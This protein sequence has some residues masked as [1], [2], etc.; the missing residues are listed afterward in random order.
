MSTA[1]I[2]I[3][4]SKPGGVPL[5]PGIPPDAEDLLEGNPA[6][7]WTYLNTGGNTKFNVSAV[8]YD[9]MNYN[10][11]IEATKINPNIDGGLG[12]ALRSIGTW[13]INRPA[14]TIFI[15]FKVRRTAT[16]VNFGGFQCS[17]E[18][19]TTIL[20]LTHHDI[21]LGTSYYLFT[22]SPYPVNPNIFNF[23]FTGTSVASTNLFSIIYIAGA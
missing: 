16:P 2:G 11:G 4:A 10:G 6:L 22:T 19:G 5:P 17:G 8:T 3:R 15:Y 21:P 7:R 1:S 18:K 12:F 9:G 20:P 14:G 23:N 13:Y